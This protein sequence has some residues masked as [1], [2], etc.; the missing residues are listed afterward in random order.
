MKEH[1]V[2]KAL[3]EKNYIDIL[4][5]FP[6]VMI[7]EEILFRLYIFVFIFRIFGLVVA[8]ILSALIF[9]IYHLHIWF[10]FKDMRITYSFMFISGLLGLILGMIIYYFGILACIFVHWSTILV[11]FYFIKKK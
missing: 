9:G 7:F 6:L 1:F 8:I 3:N 4:L 5:N 2:V 11:F 10:E